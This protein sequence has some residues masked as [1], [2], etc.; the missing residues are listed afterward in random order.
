MA[1]SSKYYA[2][3][4]GRKVGIYTSYYGGA[5]PQIKGV[6][7]AVFEGY[8]SIDKAGDFLIANG[9]EQSQVEILKKNIDGGVPKLLSRKSFNSN[10]VEDF[11]AA[12]GNIVS[13]EEFRRLQDKTQVFPL[14]KDDYVRTRLTHSIEVSIIAKQL[15]ATI[16]QKYDD[17]KNG[18]SEQKNV[19]KFTEIVD[20]NEYDLDD[21]IQNPE[22]HNAAEIIVSCASL[23][24]DLGNPPF[25]HFGEAT[26]GDWFNDANLQLLENIAKDI[27]GKAASLTDDQREGL[28]HFE[29]NA[30]ALRILSKNYYKKEKA[31][32]NPL[33][34]SFAIISA[35][36]KYPN[37]A[38][39]GIDKKGPVFRHKMG[40]NDAE[41]EAFEKMSQAVWG[42]DELIIGS[43]NRNPFAYIVEAADDI[44]YLVSDIQ[45]A[46]RTKTLSITLLKNTL[47]KYGKL[48]KE[49]IDSLEKGN[50]E[51]WGLLT[52]KALIESFVNA[53]IKKENYE[54][55]RMGELETSL[56]GATELWELEEI[57]KG[58][59]REHVY[60]HEL[61][62]KPE[63]AAVT[64]VNSLMDKFVTVAAKFA[65]L[66]DKNPQ[67]RKNDYKGLE[68]DSSR[69]AVDRKIDAYK[70]LTDPEKKIYELIP[71]NFINDFKDWYDWYRVV[72]NNKKPES[73]EVLY[74]GI[75]I[76]T[77][78]ISSMTDNHAKDVYHI[79]NPNY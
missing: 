11:D 27:T 60:E 2:V 30:Q 79:I 33:Q 6:T 46:V 22:Y 68:T 65:F 34:V 54:K 39:G 71:T 57:T 20:E 66:Y 44:G 10:D 5:E 51:K 72:N 74:H 59:L 62:V 8:D 24:H 38:T 19:K 41:K 9:I 32:S 47:E 4:K 37:L 23:L 21:V 58:L 36:V 67:S 35:M 25:G 18:F 70:K 3:A 56:F 13:S 69:R 17:G 75:L 76:A 52:R 61:L 15:M 29:G 1:N 12:Y 14:A 40:V 49:I 50:M 78:Y 63:I 28:R 7:G 26:I 48:G 45:D 42:N 64:M 55:L 16:F 73:S 77:D 53:F 31:E 43:I